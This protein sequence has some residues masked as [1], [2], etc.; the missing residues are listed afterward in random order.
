V[1]T[2]DAIDG[3]AIA[4]E[5]G[6][7]WMVSENFPTSAW[8]SHGD[9]FGLQ[10]RIVGTKNR[11]IQIAPSAAGW[12]RDAWG[13]KYRPESKGPVIK[14]KIGSSASEIAAK[15]RRALLPRYMQEWHLQASRRDEYE[16]AIGRR[17]RLPNGGT[18]WVH[19]DGKVTIT[20]D[21]ITADEILAIMRIVR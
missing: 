10:L 6:D 5:L 1:E 9:G 16:R 2:A 19:D 12:P 18:A 4:R 21:G 11:K 7:R 14:I 8:L 15:I 20:L 17:V 3:D 13:K